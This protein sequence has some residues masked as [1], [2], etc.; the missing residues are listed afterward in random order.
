MT[1]YHP[2]GCCEAGPEDYQ[3]DTLVGAKTLRLTINFGYKFLFLQTQV[4]AFLSGDGPLNHKMRLK[5]R[6]QNEGWGAT[7]LFGLAVVQT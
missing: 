1:P 2:G 7:E 5:R 6:R 3:V 4:A